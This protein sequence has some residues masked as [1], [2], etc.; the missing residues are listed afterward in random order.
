MQLPKLVT[1]SEL[2]KTT[3]DE[4]RAIHNAEPKASDA[5]MRFSECEV[6]L[7]VAV[8]ADVDGKVKFWVVEAGSGVSYENSQKVKLKFTSIPGQIVQAPAVPPGP[9]Q[10]P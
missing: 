4:L 10:L 2:V 3:A 8:A 9:A 1:L 5:V 6:E 7:A